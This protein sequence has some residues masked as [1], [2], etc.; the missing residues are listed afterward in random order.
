[1]EI[2]NPGSYLAERRRRRGKSLQ[3]VASRMGK[4]GFSK[5]ALSLIERGRMRIPKLRVNRLH[6]AYGL[7]MQER[8][9]LSLLYSFERLVEDTGEDREFAEAILSVMNP[10]RANS[11]YVIGGRQLAIN[12]RLLQEKAA[13]FL[14][15]SGN[16]L[17]FLYPECEEAHDACRKVWGSNARR[18]SLLLRQSVERL[19]KHPLQDRIQFQRI[20]V[21]EFGADTLTLNILSLCSPVTSTTIASSISSDYVIGYVYVEGP[22][23][24]WVLLKHAEAKRILDMIT[25]WLAQKKNGNIQ[26][27]D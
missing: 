7:S 26:T 9:E 18:D 12:S 19:S 17:V 14:D 5:Q 22:R 25:S 16:R 15:R 24:H 20:D 23:D 2:K 27:R 10:S 21:H 4:G 3:R 1:M 11:V 8:K 13:V 6:R